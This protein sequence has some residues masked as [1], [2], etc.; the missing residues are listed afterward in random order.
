MKIY[1]NIL[2]AF[3]AINQL[4]SQSSYNRKWGTMNYK[5]SNTSDNVANINPMNGNLYIIP[6]NPGG[7]YNE[8]IEYNINS[9]NYKLIYKFPSTASTKLEFIDFDSKG[10]IIL[11]GRTMGKAPVT[12][13]TFSQT[14]IYCSSTG[15]T[16]ICKINLNGNLIW[17]TYFYCL[18]QNQ[19]HLTVDKFDNIYFLSKRSKN[20]VIN[21]STFQSTGDTSSLQP[22]QDVISKLNSNGQHIWSTFYT[23]DQSA[24]R[25]IKAGD[26]G[27]YVYG[28][29]MDNNSNS[30]YFGATGS[31]QE[32]A[33]GAWTGIGGNENNVFLSKFDFNGKRLWSTYFA[34][35][36]SNV[37]HSEVLRYYGGLEVINNEPYILTKHE[38]KPVM[39]NNP[40]TKG[41]FLTDQVSMSQ[42]DITATKFSSDG[43]KQWCSFLYYGEALNKSFEKN[44]LIISGTAYANNIYMNNLSTSNGYQTSYGGNWSDSYTY[45]LSLDGAKMNY[46]TFYGFSGHDFGVSFGNNKGYYTFG[47][48]RI[49][50]NVISPFSSNGAPITDFHYDSILKSYFGSYISYFVNKSLST[51]NENLI[52]NN[53]FEIFPNPVESD[54]NIYSKEVLKEGTLFT[55]YDVSGKKI[56]NQKAEN[57][58]KNSVNVSQLNAGVYILTISNAE[59]SQS[60]KFIKK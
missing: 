26:D 8:I 30:N 19:S 20:D 42:Y 51:T 16:F 1:V 55:I 13:G 52:N 17:C 33:T 45:T 25:S 40:S 4:Y 57:T 50:N 36:L 7:V 60:F 5:I 10:N 35:D 23:K 14:P 9:A 39:V 24:I 22:L 56:M 48:S 27:L 38:I 54:L 21:P 18:A 12:Q 37:P 11:S 58:D 43:K 34:I 6:K 47:F 31:Y 53:I 49:N 46:G 44:E 2:C 59:Q 28:T 3:I 32:Y 29:H 15:A 41:A